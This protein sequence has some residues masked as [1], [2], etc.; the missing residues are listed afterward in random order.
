MVSQSNS[1]VLV[2]FASVLIFL[3][4][5]ASWVWHDARR[6]GAKKPVFAAVLTLFQGPLWLA[7]YL[8][9]RPLCADE[10]REGG[11]G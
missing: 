11:F 6:R 2:V 4:L 8:A 10:R 7:F 9:E 1:D 3:V 5:M